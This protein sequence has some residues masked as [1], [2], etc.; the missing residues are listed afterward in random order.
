ML[1]QE[2][3]C[4]ST[5]GSLDSGGTLCCSKKLWAQ[6]ETPGESL[7]RTKDQSMLD[8]LFHATVW[9]QLLISHH[10]SILACDWV[11]N[12]K[13]GEQTLDFRHQFLNRSSI[14]DCINY[15]EIP[16]QPSS[17]AQDVSATQNLLGWSNWKMWTLHS[18][19]DWHRTSWKSPE[20]WPTSG[21]VPEVG[22]PEVCFSPTPHIDGFTSCSIL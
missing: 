6:H 16:L 3:T 14:S 7:R 9:S 19:G 18:G 15:T 12:R 20:N 13:N 1:I 8:A 4:G 10:G 2:R 21:I 11:K 17:Q 5:I 22:V